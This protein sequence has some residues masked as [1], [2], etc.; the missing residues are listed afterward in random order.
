[1][2]WD[3]AVLSICLADVWTVVCA[4]QMANDATSAR[5]IMQMI[6]ATIQVT[7]LKGE[8]ARSFRYTTYEKVHHLAR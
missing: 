7:M 3:A 2:D 8:G 4:Q 6:A 5:L 1:M